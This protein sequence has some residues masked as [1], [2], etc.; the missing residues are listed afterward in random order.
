MEGTPVAAGLYFRHNKNGTQ[1]V[2]S[3]ADKLYDYTKDDHPVLDLGKMELPQI[4]KDFLN[5][6]GVQ[7]DKFDL[8]YKGDTSTDSI[9]AHF[10]LYKIA[11]DVLDESN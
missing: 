6:N 10:F 5:I 11:F 9:I 4:L 3:S 8:L 2:L 1:T 7:Y